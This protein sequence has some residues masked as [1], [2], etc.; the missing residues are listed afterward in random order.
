MNVLLINGPNLNLLGLREPYIYGKETLSEVEDR[1]KLRGE[2]LGLKISSFQSN[3]EGALI[4]KIQ[5]APLIFSGIII[6]PGAYGHT[7]IAL[8]DA[9]LAIRL[10]VIE[11]HISNL[12][13]REK[14]RQRNLL[15]DI[16]IGTISG[17]GVFGYELALEALI[18]ITEGGKDVSNK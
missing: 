17:L 14:F 16:V 1:V 13:R 11:V 5:S 9:L 18:D 4:D 12:A 10:P 6:N 2:R 15:S 3:H 8:R 7:S